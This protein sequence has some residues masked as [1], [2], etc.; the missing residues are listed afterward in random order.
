METTIMGLSGVWGLGFS[1][2]PHPTYA[3]QA[4]N[5]TLLRSGKFRACGPHLERLLGPEAHP[6][7]SSAYGS[8]FWDILGI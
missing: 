5:S 3:L 4:L 8:G 2:T 1:Y 7:L 6:G